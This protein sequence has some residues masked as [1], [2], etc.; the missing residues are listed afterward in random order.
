MNIFEKASRIKLRFDLNGQI[1][2][3]QLW[4]VSM[5]ALADYEQQLTEVVEGY[6]KSTRRSKKTR[7]EQQELN[8]LRLEIITYI[9]DVRETELEAAKD[10]AANK[11]NNQ[12]ILELIRSKQDQKLQEMSVEELEKLL[13]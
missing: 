5:S 3:E 13:K 8:Q 7:T 6:G 12:R 10:E 2:V 9:L 11:A 4:S 1:S